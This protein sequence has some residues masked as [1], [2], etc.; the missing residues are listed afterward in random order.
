MKAR[1]GFFLALLLVAAWLVPAELSGFIAAF[2]RDPR[3][4][5]RKLPSP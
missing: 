4:P 5:L 2:A 1:T 3:R